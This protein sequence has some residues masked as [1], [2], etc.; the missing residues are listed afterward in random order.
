[1]NKAGPASSG[2][3]H[4]GSDDLPTETVL[5]LRVGEEGSAD[6]QYPRRRRMRVIMVASAVAVAALAAGITATLH[7][8]PSPLSAVASALARTAAGSYAFSLDSATLT[9]GKERNSD[10]VTGAFDPRH[11]LSTEMLT[12]RSPGQHSVQ[13][14]IRFIGTYL[15]TRVSPGSRLPAM[16]KP[17]DKTLSAAAGGI[18]S[19][20]DYGFVSDQPVS[21]DALA[22]VLQS[23]NTSVHDSGPASGPGWTGT[24]YTFTV[25][26]GP[27]QSLDGTIYLDQQGRVRRLVTTTKQNR[28][29]IVR[30]LTISH[31]GTPVSVT[32]PPSNQVQYTSGR[33][34]WGF[35]F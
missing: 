30:D 22:A 13:A 9:A 24:R 8:A 10:V 11:G 31:F 21:P 25:H 4:G 34:Y 35:Y 26:L 27:Q 33:P 2:T 16:A 12:A 29:T 15:Y 7:G 6:Q 32:P 1:M 17:W 28:L 20:Y 3:F 5:P 19:G 18:P 23:A 14:Q